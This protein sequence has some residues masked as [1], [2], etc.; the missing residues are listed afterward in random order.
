MQ[1]SQK[2]NSALPAFVSR[3]CQ[4]NFCSPPVQCEIM[5]HHEMSEHTHTRTH[6]RGLLS[7]S[8]WKSNYRRNMW[9]PSRLSVST[10]NQEQ[11]GETVASTCFTLSAWGKHT[12]RP[13]AVCEG[14]REATTLSNLAV[15][16][17]SNDRLNKS[18]TFSL[19]EFH[20][21]QAAFCL[22]SRSRMT[23]LQI[24]TLPLVPIRGSECNF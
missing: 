8:Q 4:N 18:P 22:F 16:S 17:S 9:K 12:A 3:L 15:S 7:P 2:F 5:L 21:N 6:S 10:P 19:S 24:T 11:C 13:S 23:L 1:H 14:A 20:Q